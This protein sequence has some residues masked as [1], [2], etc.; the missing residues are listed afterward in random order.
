MNVRVHSDSNDAIPNFSLWVTDMRV[1]GEASPPF[2]L[3]GYFEELELLRTGPAAR[4]ML[5]SGRRTY[6]TGFADLFI[7]EFIKG[8]TLRAKTKQGDV[9]EFALR[10]PGRWKVSFATSA[11]GVTLLPSDLYFTLWDGRVKPEGASGLPG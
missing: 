6:A 1:D 2:Y 5:Y 3:N 10:S 8:T 9:R 11:D 4:T 7:Y